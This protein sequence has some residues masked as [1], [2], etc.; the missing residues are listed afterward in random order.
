MRRINKTIYITSDDLYLHCDHGSLALMK[1]K[2]IVARIPVTAIEQIVIF[3]NATISSYLIRFCNENHILMTYVSEYGNLY[4]NI[5]GTWYGNV[6]LRDKQYRLQ[7]SGRDIVFVRNILLGKMNN[8]RNVIMRCAK[9]ASD[10]NADALYLVADR[11]KNHISKLPELEKIEDLRIAEA[12]AASE[13]FSV[14]DNM[15]KHDDES[16]SFRKRT[17]RPPENNC[18]AIM[19]LL[20]TLF[21]GDCVAALAGNGLDV[22]KGYLHTVRAGRKSLACDLVEEF[23]ACIVDKFIITMINRRQLTGNDFQKDAAGIKLKHASLQRVL[24]EWEKYKAK[25]IVH[26]LYRKKYEQKVLPYLQA[27]LMAQYIR[28]DIPEY[29]PFIWKQ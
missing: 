2:S 4:S 8:S 12:N 17:R 28:G 18:N 7:D 25:E 9:D 14:F 13:Y 11:L 22:Y 15:L 1:E 3:G 19:S 26:P 5:I 6:D 20:Y 29:P 21:T 27:Q 10:E 16:M 23:R 24:Q